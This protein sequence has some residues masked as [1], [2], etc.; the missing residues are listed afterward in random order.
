M[1]GGDLRASLDQ[2]AF[3]ERLVAAGAGAPERH[4][5]SPGRAVASEGR[6]PDG[7]RPG[8]RARGHRGLHHEAGRGPGA[9]DQ[10]IHGLKGQGD[11]LRRLRFAARRGVPRCGAGASEDLRGRRKRAN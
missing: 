6:E 9:G 10:D 2:P 7:A 5:G 8:Q 1:Q 4:R 3:C 11:P